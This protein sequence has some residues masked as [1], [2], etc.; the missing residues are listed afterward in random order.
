MTNVVA[1]DAKTGAAIDSIAFPDVNATASSDVVKWTSADDSVSVL[2]VSYILNKNPMLAAFSLDV[3]SGG[4][5]VLLVV[6]YDG[7]RV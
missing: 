3:A 5:S 1:S 4:S 7:D 2:F 6:L